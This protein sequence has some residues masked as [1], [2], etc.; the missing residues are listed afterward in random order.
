MKSRY[1]TNP[2]SEMATGKH[3][4]GYRLTNYIVIANEIVIVTAVG[5]VVV[6]FLQ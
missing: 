5:M 6:L 4:I 2:A 1:I 3:I